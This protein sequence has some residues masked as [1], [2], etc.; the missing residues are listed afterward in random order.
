MDAG[1][2]AALMEHL[3]KN[4]W[5]HYP[6]YILTFPTR[7][8]IVSNPL[9]FSYCIKYNPF[10]ASVTDKEIG[11]SE[12]NIQDISIIFHATLNLRN[13]FCTKNLCLGRN[14]VMTN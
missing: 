5:L 12:M 4:L 6:R 8:R 2:E 10:C 3:Y 14:L 9:G 7:S 1:E 13:L 11:I